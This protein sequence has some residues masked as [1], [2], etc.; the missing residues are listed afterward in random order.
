M[1]KY[2]VTHRLST[3]YHPQ[4]S[5]KVEVSN[6]GLKRILERTIVSVGCQKPGYLAARLGYAETKVSTWDDLA[7]KLITLG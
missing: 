3:V 5:G 7:F 2:G 4:T 1:R 6:R